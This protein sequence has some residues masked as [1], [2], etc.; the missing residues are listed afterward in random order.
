MTAQMLDQV[1][2]LRKADAIIRKRYGLPVNKVQY[3]A[4]AL[5]DVQG[6]NELPVMDL[7]AITLSGLPM[8]GVFDTVP[9]L[10]Q[11]MIDKASALIAQNPRYYQKK[12]LDELAILRLIGTGARLFDPRPRDHAIAILDAR[13]TQRIQNAL[14]ADV[15]VVRAGKRP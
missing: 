5:D 4:L 9:N 6:H 10:A 2:E 12:R 7:A 13:Y 8:S 3:A 11:R 1:Q 15:R 14:P